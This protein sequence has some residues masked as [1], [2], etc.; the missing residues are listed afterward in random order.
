MPALSISTP[1]RR[2][3]ASP[4]PSP[5]PLPERRGRRDDKTYTRLTMPNPWDYKY[6]LAARRL[7]RCASAARRHKRGREEPREPSTGGL[8]EAY[9]SFTRPLKTDRRGGFDIHVYYLQQNPEQAKYARELWERIRR[10]FPE[11]RVYKFWDGPI[12]PHPVAMFEVNVFTPAQFGAFV[13]WL[14]IWRG[15][16]SALIHPNTSVPEGEAANEVELRDHTERAIWNGARGCRWI[17]R[18]SDLTSKRPVIQYATSATI[19]AAPETAVATIMSV[20]NASANVILANWLCEPCAWEPRF[21][22]GQ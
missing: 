10:E 1:S 2:M 13:A 8:S 16:L 4:C 3:L 5:V 18:H 11:L 22:D 17:G 19:T 7:R 15:P 9:R 6:P 21:S 20:R 12:G 14:A